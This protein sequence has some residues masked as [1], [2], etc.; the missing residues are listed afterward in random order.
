[1][2]DSPPPNI[3]RKWAPNPP[4]SSTVFRAP[5]SKHQ[6][7]FFDKYNYIDCGCVYTNINININIKQKYLT[8][9]GLRAIKKGTW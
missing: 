3:E 4:L 6:N 5:N 1:M 8:Q 2:I 9:N 7:N